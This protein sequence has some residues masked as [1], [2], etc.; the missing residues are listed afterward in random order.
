MDPT[1]QKLLIAQMEHEANAAQAYRA[2]E[3]W[4]QGAG[5]LGTAKWCGA[6][7]TEEL[8][9]QHAIMSFLVDYL[10]VGVAAPAVEQVRFTGGSLATLFSTALELERENLEQWS[11]IAQAATAEDVPEVFA[12][13]Q[14]FLLGQVE[15]ISS[16]ATI[17][18]RLEIAKTDPSALLQI[19]AWIGEGA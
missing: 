3:S 8:D 6:Q 14:A 7:V 4:A 2:R 11:T 18:S 1:V 12:F 19:D 9:H 17:R 10:G 15:S 5:W 13:A 16:L